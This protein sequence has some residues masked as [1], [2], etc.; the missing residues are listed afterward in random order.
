MDEGY[1]NCDL[2][3]IGYFG[4][5]Y[6]CCRATIWLLGSDYRFLIEINVFLS[7]F[8]FSFF[9][10]MQQLCH[11][12]FLLHSFIRFQMREKIC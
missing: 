10:F 6:E 5:S 12:I 8:L 3:N 7:D 9:Q 11:V 4:S 2:S 1:T